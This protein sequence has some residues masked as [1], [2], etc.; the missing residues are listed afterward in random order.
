MTSCVNDPELTRSKNFIPENLKK[1][2]TFRLLKN[3]VY[4]TLEEA[5]F[6]DLFAERFQILPDK[7]ARHLRHLSLQDRAT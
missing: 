1:Y 4:F 3:L 7:F 2:V 6:F 5:Q